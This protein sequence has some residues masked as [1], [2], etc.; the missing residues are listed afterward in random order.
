MARGDRV[1]IPGPDQNIRAGDKIV[2]FNTRPGV[3]DIGGTFRAA[4]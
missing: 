3:A 4:A 2:V 1:I